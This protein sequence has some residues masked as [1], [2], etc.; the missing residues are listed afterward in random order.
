ME[1]MVTSQSTPSQ[2]LQNAEAAS[3]SSLENGTSENLAEPSISQSD[4]EN[5]DPS[6][7]GGAE[8][9]DIIPRRRGRPS[10]RFLG[11]KYRKYMGRR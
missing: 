4:S 7:K 8:D 1:P 6:S 10:R 11:K 5:K 9:A 3:S 2:E